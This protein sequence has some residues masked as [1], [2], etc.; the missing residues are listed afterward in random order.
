[1]FRLE[2]NFPN[3]FNAGTTIRYQLS[4]T[5]WVELV[6]YDLQ[7]NLVRALAN[8][9][10]P[11]GIQTSTW[12]GR[13]DVGRLAASGVY[14]FKLLVRSKETGGTQYVEVKKMVLM[15]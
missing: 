15:K 2:Q 12:D 14:F 8:G 3:P 13:N 1:L 4:Q 5:A 10:K 6:I 7:G 9:A 11:A